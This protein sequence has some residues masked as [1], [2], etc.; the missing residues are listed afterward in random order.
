MNHYRFVSL[1]LGVVAVADA[2]F[3]TSKSFI[4]SVEFTICGNVADGDGFP[5]VGVT[6]NKESAAAPTFFIHHYDSSAAS[7]VFEI[8]TLPTTVGQVIAVEN[9]LAEAIDAAGGALYLTD[10]VT[11]STV[12]D[13]VYW[14]TV[15]DPAGE[16]TL[17]QEADPSLVVYSLAPKTP[18][19]GGV[20]YVGE[21]KGDYE[22]KLL[23]GELDD[24]SV[25][26]MVDDP[27]AAATFVGSNTATAFVN[28][29]V[30][31][32]GFE[33]AVYGDG[34]YTLYVGNG[35][36]TGTVDEI[37]TITGGLVGQWNFIEAPLTDVSAWDAASGYAVLAD[38]ADDTGAILS[39][40][41][42]GDAAPSSH[43]ING[44]G[45]V[46]YPLVV[47]AADLIADDGLYV[48][49]EMDNSGMGSWSH[50][51]GYT[52]SIGSA[53]KG[54]TVVGGGGGTGDET[55]DAPPAGG[56]GTTDG[57]GGITKTTTTTLG[58]EET[59]TAAESETGRGH[60][61]KI[62]VFAVMGSMALVM[63]S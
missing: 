5:H 10:D 37:H 36:G 31:G 49:G 43:E 22:G 7:V 32:V 17:I 2:G 28:E 6:L 41:A 27:S 19:G 57:G 14:G 26:C 9:I 30:F 38:T 60:T 8:A 58:G 21:V 18:V 23:D 39:S 51:A 4:H 63:S 56:E 44:S 29:I 1:L 40:I 47:Y 48:T 46:V 45:V 50:E 16:C 55:T 54:Q 62:G 3:E 59:T 42:W 24:K 12:F 11:G 52:S 13:C 35:K 20:P 34:V 53:N 33:V 15:A 61:S 25:V